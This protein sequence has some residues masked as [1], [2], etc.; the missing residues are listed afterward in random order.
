MLATH[1]VVAKEAQGYFLDPGF[2]RDDEVVPADRKS[3]S[4]R[5]PQ[6]LEF[7][8]FCRS[9]RGATDGGA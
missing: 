4:K 2:R 5:A 1:H 3:G 8:V 7:K 6:A 9:A